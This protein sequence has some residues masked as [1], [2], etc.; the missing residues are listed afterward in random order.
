M[1]SNKEQSI[2]GDIGPSRE[3]SFIWWHDCVEFW[4]LLTDSWKDNFQFWKK[5]FDCSIRRVDRPIERW[6][7]VRA[8]ANYPSTFLILFAQMSNSQK[9]RHWI[10]INQL[11]VRRDSKKKRK[12]EKISGAERKGFT[13]CWLV[14]GSL[15]NLEKWEIGVE[16]SKKKK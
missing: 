2:F 12:I 13:V 4:K 8:R 14:Y 6:V 15:Y 7:S 11:M 10:E 5:N 3:N 16:I 1:T 9:M